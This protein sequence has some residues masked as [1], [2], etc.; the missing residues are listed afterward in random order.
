M[1]PPAL[2]G[3]ANVLRRNSAAPYADVVLVQLRAQN[4]DME[5]DEKSDSD[6]DMKKFNSEMYSELRD[7]FAVCFCRVST[8]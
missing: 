1:C 7:K 8:E 2:H 4:K 6:E 3:G 5:G